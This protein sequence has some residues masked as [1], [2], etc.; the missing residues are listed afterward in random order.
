MRRAKYRQGLEVKA[1]YDHET[2]DYLCEF[3][4]TGSISR[5]KEKDLY[6][7]ESTQEAEDGEA[8]LQS[9]GCWTHPWIYDGTQ[10]LEVAQLLDEY[11][12]QAVAKAVRE[13]R[14]AFRAMIKEA[15]FKGKQVD[16]IKREYYDTGVLDA[17]SRIGLRLKERERNNLTKEQ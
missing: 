3:I 17:V 6:W 5:V 10:S 16:P 15:T 7:I 11:A 8:F 9:K 14:E 2:D 1:F 12:S 13:E 4:K